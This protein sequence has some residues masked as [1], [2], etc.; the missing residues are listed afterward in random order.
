MM[1]AVA[2]LC[3]LAACAALGAPLVSGTTGFTGAQFEALR[4]H[5]ERHPV[6]HATNFSLGIPALQMLLQLLARTLPAGAQVDLVTHS[7]GGIVGDLLCVDWNDAVRTQELI[8]GYA[9]FRTGH[10]KDVE[11]SDLDEADARDR[12]DRRGGGRGRRR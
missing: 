9:R 10:N 1:R 8:D 5:A 2:L 11:D 3:L 7:R 12:R 4:R 6:V